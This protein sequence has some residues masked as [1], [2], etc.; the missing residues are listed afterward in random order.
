[1][2]STKALTLPSEED[3]PNFSSW[4]FHTYGQQYPYQH[5]GP[6]SQQNWHIDARSEFSD[7]VAQEIAREAI[8]LLKNVGHHLPIEKSNGIRRLLIVGSAQNTDRR[9]VNCKDQRCTEGVLTSGWGSAAV[10]NPIVVT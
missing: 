8:I 5:Y 6:I 3:I 10:N 1:F 9:G 4:T 7:K 2:F